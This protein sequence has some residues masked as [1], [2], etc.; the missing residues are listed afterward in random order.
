MTLRLELPE[1]QHARLEVFNLLGQNVAT[2]TDNLTQAGVS[3]FRWDAS[4]ASSGVY[5]Y[6]LTAGSH[7]E[8]HKML[9]LK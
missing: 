6:R 5:I 3:T 1:A 4:Q 8:S 7:I 9:L 2:L